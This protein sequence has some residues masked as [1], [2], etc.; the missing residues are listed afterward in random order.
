MRQKVNKQTV[1]NIL[2]GY[3]DW[4]RRHQPSLT[5]D[6]RQE[7]IS[8]IDN[9][10][11]Y[12]CVFPNYTCGECGAWLTYQYEE[13]SLTEIVNQTCKFCEVYEN[14]LKKPLSVAEGEVNNDVK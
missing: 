5:I 11:K 13:A 1:L 4:L 10:I 8:H 14:G 12:E 2:Y 7:M 9:Y 6:Q 3:V